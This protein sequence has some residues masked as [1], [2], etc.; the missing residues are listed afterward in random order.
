MLVLYQFIGLK[1]QAVR[2][3]PQRKATL[4]PGSVMGRGRPPPP[5]GATRCLAA[6]PRAAGDPGQWDNGPVPYFVKRCTEIQKVL[7]PH[8]IF[9]CIL[10]HINPLKIRR[11]IY[12]IRYYPVKLLYRHSSNCTDQ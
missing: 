2:S 8:P 10:L 7:L 1:I 12:L 3:R 11:V 6:H 5:P 9:P 4:A